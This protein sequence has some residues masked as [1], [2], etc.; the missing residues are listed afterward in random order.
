MVGIEQEFFVPFGSQ[1][2]AFRDAGLESELAR[3]VFDALAGGVMQSRFPNDPAFSN[4]P[5]ADLELRL[6]QYNHSAGRLEER[7]GRGK[8]QRDRDE[9]D[10]AR[11][12]R[13]EL[14]DLGVV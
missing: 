6:D 2:G 3:R 11:D 1:N 14:A 4:L 5:F 10:I 13:Y 8:D 7:H 12:E 9:T